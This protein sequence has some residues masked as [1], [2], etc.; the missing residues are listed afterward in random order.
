MLKNSWQG[1]VLLAA[2]VLSGCGAGDDLRIAGKGVTRIHAQMDREQYAD[3][4]AQAD[5][6]FRSATNQKDFLASVGAI[7]RKLGKVQDTSQSRYFLNFT[8][9][10]PQV[11]LNYHT[12]FEEGDGQEEFVWKIKDNNAVLVGYHINSTALI[13]K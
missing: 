10:G 7:H 11:R 6:S 1:F 9:S 3:I 4:Y 8:T 5:D 13:I 2:L 12:K